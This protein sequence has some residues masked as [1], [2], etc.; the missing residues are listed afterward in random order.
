MYV[1]IKSYYL[2]ENVDKKILSE[3]GFNIVGA[4]MIRDIPD[5]DFYTI[6]YYNTKRVAI[7]KYPWV[8]TRSRK[9]KKYILDLIEK[10]LVEEKVNYEWWAIIGSY[11]NYSDKK[12]ERIKNKLN[13]LNKKV[14]ADLCL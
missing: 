7:K 8:E 14:G 2:K 1:K 5:K 12:M 9:V 6:I 4:N 11:R 13:K 10:D 3:L